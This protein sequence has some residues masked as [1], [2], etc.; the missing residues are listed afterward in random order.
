MSAPIDLLAAY[1]T[2]PD[3]AGY[4]MGLQM[5]GHR[6]E[7]AQQYF[8]LRSA[9][10]VSGYMTAIEAR[11]RI[12]AAL[13]PPQPVGADDGANRTP[14]TEALPIPGDPGDG[15][16]LIAPDPARP[17]AADGAARP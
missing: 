10:G 5:G 17:G 1:L 14:P 13:A 8:A 16:A 4:S 12:V 15:R 3:V 9:F 11:K 2:G 7:V 6:A